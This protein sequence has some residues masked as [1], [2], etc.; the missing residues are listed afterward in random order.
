MYDIPGIRNSRV[1]IPALDEDEK[2]T[3]RI[4]DGIQRGNPDVSIISESRLY[5]PVINIHT[6]GGEQEMLVVNES[7]LYHPLFNFQ[8]KRTRNTDGVRKPPDRVE[9]KKPR[10]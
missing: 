7:G 4:S 6:L 2:N 3:V 9:T 8:P 1:T 5:N 10:M